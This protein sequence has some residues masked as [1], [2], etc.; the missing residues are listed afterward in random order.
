MY[1]TST[2]VT[3]YV[4]LHTVLQ[5]SFDNDIRF[6]LRLKMPGIVVLSHHPMTI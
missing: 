4:Q 5:L 1:N 3:T 2:N 6:L